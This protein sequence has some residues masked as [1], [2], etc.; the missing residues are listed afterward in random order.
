LVVSVGENRDVVTSAMSHWS[1]EPTCCS[2]IQEAM[3]L[4]PQTSPFL[5]FCEERLPDG[6]YKDLLREIGKSTK[7]RLVV[8]SPNAE[9]DENYNEAIALGAFDMIASPSRRSDVQ[10][11]AIRAMHEDARRTASKRRPRMT[12]HKEEISPAPEEASRIGK[13]TASG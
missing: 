3:S 11:I 12:P 13:G 4:L 8:I 10:W 9:F 5:I 1:M 2:G 7:S 6:T